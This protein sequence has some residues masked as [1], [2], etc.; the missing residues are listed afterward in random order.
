MKVKFGLKDEIKRVL[1]YREGLCYVEKK[2]DYSIVIYLSL[3]GCSFL[4]AIFVVFKAT[5]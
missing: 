2:I 3:I 1:N 5:T 4:F